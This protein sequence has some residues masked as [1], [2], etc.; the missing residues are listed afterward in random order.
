M[1]AHPKRTRAE[2]P[3]TAPY[4]YEC[5]AGHYVEA[6]RPVERCPAC[7]LGESCAAPLHPATR[8]RRR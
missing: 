1:I 6:E 2:V 5:P 4:R 8:R 3:W 7:H